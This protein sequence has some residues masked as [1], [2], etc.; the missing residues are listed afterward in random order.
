MFFDR[1]ATAASIDP[2]D[3]N[4][5]EIKNTPESFHVAPAWARVWSTTLA[6]ILETTKLQINSS[7]SATVDNICT[8]MGVLCT[9]VDEL[10]KIASR[11]P[12]MHPETE[13]LRQETRER[14][15]FLEVMV[16]N[17]S[18]RTVP[19]VV[20]TIP[21]EPIIKEVEKIV[22]KDVEVR[23]E[24]PVPAQ[25]KFEDEIGN[26]TDTQLEECAKLLTDSQLLTIVRARK[27]K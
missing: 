23:V 27:G 25:F 22:Y 12:V 7:V 26:F 10:I 16:T 13:L 17:L 18:N 9:K 8:P 11:P 21:C 1:K 20:S 4:Q 19:G 24:V 15:K 14:I 5:R 2:S 6:S 3:I